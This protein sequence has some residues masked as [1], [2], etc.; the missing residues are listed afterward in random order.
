MSRPQDAL[1]ARTFARRP[2]LPL[3]P[4]AILAVAFATWVAMLALAWRSYFGMVPATGVVA[5][6]ADAVLRGQAPGSEDGRT[7]LATFYL[8]PFP[9]LVAA[10]RGLGLEWL[11]ALRGAALVAALLV[12]AACGWL[13]REMNAGQGG[14]VLAC[15]LVMAS[16]TFRAS[17]LGGRADLLAAAF[18][19]AGLAAWTRDER[20]RGWA[21]PALAA[22]SFLTK[23]TS[24]T[25][26]LAL[27]W[28][29]LRRREG[30]ALLGFGAR[31]AAC[32]LAGIAL[33]LPAHGPGWYWDAF[34]ALVVATPSTFNSLRGPAE[35][36]RYLGAFSELALFAAMAL[37]LVTGRVARGKPWSAFLG[38]SLAIT[39]YVMTNFGAG[40]NH[41]DEITCAAAVCA[42]V[43]AAR[44]L[45]RAARLPAFALVLVVTGA[46]WRDL[47][48]VARYASIPVNLRT[49]AI[50]AVR[51]EPGEVLTEDALLALA[52]G[53]RPAITDPGAL[54]SM[55]LAG[56]PRA[57]RIIRRI[58]RADYPLVII[59]EDLDQAATWYHT[60]HLGDRTIGALRS[61]Y[62][63]VAVLDNYHLFRPVER[64]P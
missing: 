39:S 40:P 26:P 7:L 41:L 57:L 29:T 52:A 14:V 43:W 27:V 23:A 53:R 50:A 49:E 9:L 35:L 31:F 64:A 55:S 5:G 6:L 25:L 2:A 34:H 4:T 13:A 51:A 24:L 30:R 18:S 1:G 28:W 32:A 11:A 42:A 3:I 47:I 63:E 61:R 10:G 20:L 21:T 16:Y 19:I 62:R 37:A 45:A 48:P 56:D 12:L 17:S 59:N 8:P 46:A 22:A 54:R 38:A 58:E 36:L 60:V 33:T 44:R 15:A